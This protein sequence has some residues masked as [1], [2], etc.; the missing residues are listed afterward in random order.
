[1]E[2][3]RVIYRNWDGFA[4]DYYEEALRGRGEAFPGLRRLTREGTVFSQAYSGIP[5]LDYPA[6]GQHDTLDP[7]SAHVFLALWGEGVRPGQ[8]V[9]TPV[10]L[11]DLAPTLAALLAMA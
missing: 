6:R 4:W 7:T 11:I 8:R 5:S 9:A 10:R 2:R 3:R 1:M